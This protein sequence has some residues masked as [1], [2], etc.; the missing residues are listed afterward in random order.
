MQEEFVNW[1]E[2]HPRD[3]A[4]GNIYMSTIDPNLKA[5]LLISQHGYGESPKPRIR[6]RALNQCLEKL[7]A[8]AQEKGASIHMPRIGSG[9]AGG[10]WPV[11]LE[12]IEESL[13]KRGVEVTIYDL[14]HAQPKE[15]SQ[16]LF[17]FSHHSVN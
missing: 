6:Y 14:P 1:T 15:K 7:A 9:Q 13:S 10:H 2:K 11:I 4:L 12:M 5:A 3:F 16:G 17:D 8:V